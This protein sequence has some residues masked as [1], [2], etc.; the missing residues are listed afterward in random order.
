M[1]VADDDCNCIAPQRR[2]NTSRGA[3]RDALT[4]PTA[5]VSRAMGRCRASSIRTTISSRLATRRSA[6][7]S[8][9]SRGEAMAGRSSGYQRSASS[10][11]AASRTARCAL[12]PWSRVSPAAP[13]ARRSQIGMRASRVPMA[14]RSGAGS[15]PPSTLAISSASPSSLH[16]GEAGASTRRW[17]Y[18][19]V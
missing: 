19:F 14:R 2:P 4:V 12:T 17:Y 7:S 8:T 15:A 13:S 18:R 9:A 16:S 6:K 3:S 5:T 1:V 11:S 10:Q